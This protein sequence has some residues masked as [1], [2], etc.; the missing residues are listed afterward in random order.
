M[1]I[2]SNTA[3][4][5][6][7]T[8]QKSVFFKHIYLFKI[9]QRILL[10]A[11]LSMQFILIF[12]NALRKLSQNRARAV[13]FTMQVHVTLLPMKHISYN[14]RNRIPVESWS[15]HLSTTLENRS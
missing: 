12:E 9:E 6:Y 3:Q 5:F 7:L 14:L 15:T 2:C 1:T 11:R 8:A 10:L 4:R 13:L